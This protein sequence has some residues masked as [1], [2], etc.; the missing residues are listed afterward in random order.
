MKTGSFLFA[1]VAAMALSA[2]GDSGNPGEGGAV[3]EALQVIDESRVAD[4]LSAE[5]KAALGIVEQGVRT[6]I[7]AYKAQYGQ[8]PASY[9][10]LAS[11][12]TA[13]AAAVAV[14][15]DGLGEQ[16]P[17]VRRETLE[18]VSAQFVGRAQQRIFEQIKGQEQAASAP[19]G[20]AR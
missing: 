17:F 13:R 20:Q 3:G 4:L 2:C 12:E 16:L 1:A 14:I 10:D 9:A 15:A 11:L 19:E 6:E 7:A 5:G 8:L 18:Q